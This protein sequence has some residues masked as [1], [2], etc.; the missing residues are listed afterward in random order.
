MHVFFFCFCFFVCLFV[1]VVVVFFFCLFVFFVCFLFFTQLW[2]ITLF[3]SLFRAIKHDDESSSDGRTAPSSVCF[4]RPLTI[5]VCDR[6]YPDF[7]FGFLLLRFQ[8]AIE[9]SLRRF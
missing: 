1:V 9:L 7:T 5:A 2:L 3:L 8:V 4:V 6:A